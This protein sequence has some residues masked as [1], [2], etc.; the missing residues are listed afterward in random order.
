MNVVTFFQSQIRFSKTNQK[1]QIYRLFA[2]LHSRAPSSLSPRWVSQSH[3]SRIWS[4]S[5]VAIVTLRFAWNCVFKFQLAG[6]VAMDLTWVYLVPRLSFPCLFVTELVNWTF[7]FHHW[8]LLRVAF[9]MFIRCWAFSET[10][11]FSPGLWEWKRKK[12]RITS[13]TATGRFFF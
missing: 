8:C 13:H 11:L 1:T 6:F 4:I 5:Y 3:S 7:F 12:K 2:P 10:W 9:F